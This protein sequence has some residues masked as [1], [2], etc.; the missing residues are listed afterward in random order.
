MLKGTCMHEVTLGLKQFAGL[1]SAGDGQPR[2][3]CHLPAGGCRDAGEAAQLADGHPARY[4][5][6]DC[7][8]FCGCFMI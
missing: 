3:I 5:V 7:R 2:V 8:K 4:P 6:T 1:S